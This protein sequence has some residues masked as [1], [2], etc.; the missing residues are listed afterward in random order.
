MMAIAIIPASLT[1]RQLA[2][3]TSPGSHKN[4]AIKSYKSTLPVDIAH[5]CIA[6]L[7]DQNAFSN[8]V[9]ISSISS[10]DRSLITNHKSSQQCSTAMEYSDIPDG[11]FWNLGFHHLQPAEAGI[12]FTKRID[13]PFISTR[14]ARD[15]RK[16]L[17]PRVDTA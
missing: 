2:D 15:R 8:H 13:I 17:L 16:W 7:S 14:L 4:L 10:Y 5:I 1:I 3:T 9:L 12:P 6:H 11:T